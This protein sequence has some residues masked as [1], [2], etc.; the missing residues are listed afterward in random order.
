[1]VWFMMLRHDY[2]RFKNHIHHYGIKSV[3][4][5]LWVEFTSTIRLYFAFLRLAHSNHDFEMSDK[6]D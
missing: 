5:A 1:M 2:W 3:I 4:K 6:Y